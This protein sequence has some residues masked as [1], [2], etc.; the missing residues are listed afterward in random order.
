MKI[1]INGEIST[2]R[3]RIAMIIILICSGQ[4]QLLF[5]KNES[6]LSKMY[7]KFKDLITSKA[8]RKNK[9]TMDNVYLL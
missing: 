1:I 3:H 5:L 6:D 7:L 4:F 2:E 9:N 8:I